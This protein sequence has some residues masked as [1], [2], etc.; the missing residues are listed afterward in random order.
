[1]TKPTSTLPPSPAADAAD[2]AAD[3]RLL[4]SLAALSPHD[5]ASPTSVEHMHARARRVFEREARLAQSPALRRASHLYGRVLEPSA[6]AFAAVVYL[7]WA[8]ARVL[9]VVG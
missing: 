4:D 2:A 8:F 6:V 9:G 7:A 3:A 1:M 5:V